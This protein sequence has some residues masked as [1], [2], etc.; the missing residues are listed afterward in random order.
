MKQLFHDNLLEPIDKV[1][2]TFVSHHSKNSRNW[3]VAS[4]IAAQGEES[5]QLKDICQV[6]WLKE[7]A[8][9]YIVSGGKAEK[10]R[11]GYLSYLEIQS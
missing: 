10:Y 4:M 3:E 6:Q 2:A 7:A 11:F 5:E 8:N 9:R 1:H